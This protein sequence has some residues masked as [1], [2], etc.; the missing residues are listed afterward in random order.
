MAYISLRGEMGAIAQ[1]V[2][3]REG[4]LIVCGPSAMVHHMQHESL[5]DPRTKEATSECHLS[6]PLRALDGIRG[7]AILMV[8]A[9]RFNIGPDCDQFPGRLLFKVL[10][11]GDLG[12]DLF[13]VLSGFLITGILFDSKGKDH[14]FRNF[15]ARRALRIF[16]LYYGFLFVTLVALPML[17]GPSGNLFPEATANQAWLWL[18]GANILMGI[19]NEWCLGSFTHFWSL[20][21][22][23]HFYLVWPFVIVLCSRRQAM[24]ISLL[25]IALSIVGRILWLGVVGTE[26][27]VD[28]VTLFRMD[29]LALGSLLALAARGP[30]GI[31]ALNPWAVTGGAACALA[32]LAIACLPNP[33]LFG[34]PVTVVAAFFGALLVLAVDSN[35][36][37]WWGK[38]W[39][40]P[41]LGF[42]GKYS[43]A[44]YVF[45]L[46][47]I[48]L[49][50]PILTPEGT[51][52]W[53]G[54]AF[55]GRLA[56]IAVMTS[57][58]TL[59]AVGSWHLYEKHFL[60]LKTRFQ[61]PT[62]SPKLKDPAEFAQSWKQYSFVSA[63]P[64][65]TLERPIPPQCQ[66]PELG[67]SSN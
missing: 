45:Q 2:G 38:T 26:V 51:S 34:L 55:A 31:R 13:F 23:E 3:R 1:R 44:M 62:D 4:R 30:N 54:S 63:N 64:P 57:V 8:T 9:Y 6:G 39:R 43:Y 42:F 28:T 14:F 7:L 53:L 27:P 36:A 47:L 10:N 21:V 41:I 32:M 11:Y 20:S 15:Y 37:T 19:R 67:R 18:Y 40:S 52:S 56:Y 48:A 49:M 66:E 22:E 50:T 5:R 12:V 60:A 25:A 46:P 24:L 29:G 16:P 35:A 61:G 58:T 59:A 17:Y 65:Q 33:R